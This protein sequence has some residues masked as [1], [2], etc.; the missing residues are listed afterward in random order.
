MILQN[1]ELDGLRILGTMLFP[2][3]QDYRQRY[4]ECRE[5]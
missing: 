1:D 4:V 3:N 5:R 2:N